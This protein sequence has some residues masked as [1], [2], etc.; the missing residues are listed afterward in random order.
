MSSHAEGWHVLGVAGRLHGLVRYDS[1]RRFAAMKYLPISQAMLYEQTMGDGNDIDD[2][3]DKEGEFLINRWVPQGILWEKLLSAK[4]EPFA[5]FANCK[6]KRLI[7]EKYFITGWD[8]DE[9]FSSE[10][11]DQRVILLKEWCY[12][13]TDFLKNGKIPEL[14]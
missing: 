9:C 10:T 1:Y 2:I 13:A 5:V 14:N 8:A 11:D 6:W 3:D 12:F 4:S 7:E